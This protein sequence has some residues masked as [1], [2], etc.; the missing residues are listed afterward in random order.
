MAFLETKHTLSRIS[1]IKKDLNN[2]ITV[3]SYISMA[4]FLAYYIYLLILNLH[5]YFYIIIYSSLIAVIVSLFIIE[6]IIRDNKKILKNEKR[7]VAEKKRRW[8][9]IIKVIKFLAKFALV[10]VALYETF[11]NFNL[12]I[13]NM[14]NICSLITLILQVLIEI[15][16]YYIVLQIDYFR[17]STELDLD[18][19]GTVIKKLMKVINP[20]KNLEEE[21]IKSTNG[22][23]YSEQELKMIEEIKK[24]AEK[25][26]K[27][28]QEK[29]NQIKQMLPAKRK[30]R[31]KSKS[32]NN[33]D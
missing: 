7:L 2:V 5:E 26:I 29:E 23:L 16:I 25:F 32:E 30:T 4:I 24:D 31:K 10:F 9:T 12:S 20:I 14:I 18:A 8:K 19:S 21:A 13:S 1:R 33:V 15:V 3:I 28:K 6:L 11:T 27:E 22:A 17:L